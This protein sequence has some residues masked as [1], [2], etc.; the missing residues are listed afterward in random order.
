MRQPL[1]AAAAAGF[2]G[3]C[4]IS[5]ATSR[6]A[7]ARG[8][9]P[10]A[11]RERPALAPAGLRGLAPLPALR[12][13]R[14]SARAAAAAPQTTPVVATSPPA[15]PPPAQQPVTTPSPPAPRPVAAPKEPAPSPAP[16]FDSS[17]EVFDSS[18]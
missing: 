11:A 18:E 5:V 2:I 6:E 9:D 12:R 16:E 7:P 15:A 14:L 13:A 8:G 3:A 10:V 1:L 17:E 4:G